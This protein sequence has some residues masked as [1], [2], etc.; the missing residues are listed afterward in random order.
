M[1]RT[2]EREK[3]YEQAVKMV[4]TETLVHAERLH[5]R[6]AMLGFVIGIA[7]EVFTGQSVMSQ[8]IKGLL[9]IQLPLE[10]LGTIRP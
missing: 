3:R 6:T 1:V 8:I 7:I 2:S 4:R 9:G 5:G 10:A